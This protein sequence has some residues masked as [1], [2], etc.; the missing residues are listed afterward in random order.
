[1]NNG[2]YEIFHGGD[3]TLSKYFHVFNKYKMPKIIIIVFILKKKK[4][5]ENIH[6]W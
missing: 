1:V 2:E 6:F 3:K 4:I 5:I